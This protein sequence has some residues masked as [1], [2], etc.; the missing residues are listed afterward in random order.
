MCRR[1]KRRAAYW[2]AEEKKNMRGIHVIFIGLIFLLLIGASVNAEEPS[3]DG[4]ELL[5]DCETTKNVSS[6]MWCYGY[7]N[8]ILD[9]QSLTEGNPYLPTL[10]TPP[11]VTMEQA[12]RVVVKYLQNHPEKLHYGE[13]A[14]TYIALIEA[15]P[16]KAQPAP[17]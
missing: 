12:R 15:F 11:E 10:C 9:M 3:G 17:E 4:K 13:H 16:C 6:T 14:L 7:L 8:G 1:C 2:P 5:R